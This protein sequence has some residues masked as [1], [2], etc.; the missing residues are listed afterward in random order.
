M[1]EKKSDFCESSPGNRKP[2][3]SRPKNTNDRGQVDIFADSSCM[4]LISLI[5]LAKLLL[6]S[7][8]RAGNSSTFYPSD[9]GRGRGTSGTWIETSQ[10]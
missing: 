9:W 10:S 7:R 1:H 6:A 8:E 4:V 3:S 5:K 2:K